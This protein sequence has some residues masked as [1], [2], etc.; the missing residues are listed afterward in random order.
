MTYLEQGD[1]KAAA[2]Q[3]REVLRSA[4]PQMVTQRQRTAKMYLDL[5]GIR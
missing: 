2:V 5:I 3:F 4:T 1:N